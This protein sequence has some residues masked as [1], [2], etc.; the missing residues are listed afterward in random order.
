MFRSCTRLHS[1]FM[2]KK[3]AFLLLET[4]STCFYVSLEWAALC[5]LVRRQKL[6]HLF[7]ATN[8]VRFLS[9]VFC[10][11]FCTFWLQCHHIWGVIKMNSTQMCITHFAM[12]LVWFGFQITICEWGL[13]SRIINSA[14]IKLALPLSVIYNQ[15][16]VSRHTFC[17]A[18]NEPKRVLQKNMQSSTPENVLP[19]LSWVWQPI[20]VNGNVQKNA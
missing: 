11:N 19:H 13:R 16:A 12:I 20:Q 5:T 6:L 14:L 7:Q 4:N 8:F 15:N 1:Y 17:C 2:Y 9:H 10:C 3:R 18:T